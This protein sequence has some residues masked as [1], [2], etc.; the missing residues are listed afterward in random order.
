[1]FF[2]K[3]PQEGRNKRRKRRISK[4]IRNKYCKVQFKKNLNLN[5]RI[6]HV[7]YP[8][9]F[10]PKSQ[11]WGTNLWIYWTLKVENKSFGH[12]SKKIKHVYIEKNKAV[13]R[14]CHSDSYYK[15]AEEQHW[16]DALWR[17]R[18][19]IYSQSNSH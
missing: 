14:L 17:A 11:Y 3:V 5:I 7:P 19:E 9:N 18:C 16:Q 15:K 6:Y 10:I 12:P 13:H 2:L 1:M 4:S 8:A